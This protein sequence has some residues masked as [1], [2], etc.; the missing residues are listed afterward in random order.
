MCNMYPT[1]NSDIEYPFKSKENIPYFLGTTQSFY[2]LP[3]FIILPILHFLVF[4]G[5]MG[6][7]YYFR[8]NF[9]AIFIRSNKKD[10]K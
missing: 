2:N 6:D 3:T 10:S 5:S 7:T 1:T 9:F 4:L 8:T